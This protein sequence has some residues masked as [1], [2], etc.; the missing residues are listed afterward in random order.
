MKRR[1]FLAISAAT[2]AATKASAQAAR[3]DSGT[4]TFGLITDVQYADADPKGE[5]H[6][7]ES[8]PKLKEAVKWLSG[9][10]LPFTLHLGD[11]IDRDFKSFATVLPLLDGLG[12]P[13]R[14]LLGNHDYTMDDAEKCRVVSTLGMPHDYYSFRHS[15]VRFILLDTNDRS[16]YKYPA[17]HRSTQESARML[18]KLVSEKSNAAQDWNGGLSETQLD[19]LERELS[20]ADVEKEPVIV[21]GHHPLLPAEGHQ[22]WNSAEVVAILEKHASVKAYFGGHF[23]DG[24]EVIQNGIPYITFKSLLHEPGVT[25]YC[26][27]RLSPDRLEIE[28]RG[29]EVSRTLD[30][31]KA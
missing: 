1:H 13:V 31:R 19:W 6:F 9:K 29:R 27:I 25:S 12:H 21:C 2:A 16:V 15:G 20:A 14:H 28:G 17:S 24:S 4:L 30:L 11:F 3:E 22:A 26:V 18:Q 23:H 5:R 10:Q 7:R 8:V